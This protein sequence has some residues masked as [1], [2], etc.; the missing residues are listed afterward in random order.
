MRCGAKLHD[1]RPVVEAVG[2]MQDDLLAVDVGIHLTGLGGRGVDDEDIT[3]VEVRGQVAE[4][5]VLHPARR[6][7]EEAGELPVAYVV[8]DAPVDAAALDAECRRALASFKVP[9]AFVRVEA[10]PRTALGK[11]QKHLLPPW[12]EAGRS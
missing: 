9:R 3:G 12:K 8:S 1:S 6:P 10:L 5:R 11:I 4:A 7:D 2:D